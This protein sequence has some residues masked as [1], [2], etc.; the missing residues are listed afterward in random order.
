[1]CRRSGNRTVCLVVF[2]EKILRWFGAKNCLSILPWRPVFPDSSEWAIRGPSRHHVV[3]S[4]TNQIFFYEKVFC[5]FQTVPE[6]IVDEREIQDKRLNKV[7]LDSWLYAWIMQQNYAYYRWCAIVK[8]TDF[9][10]VKFYH[11][12]MVIIGE[13]VSWERCL[14]WT[15]CSAYWLIRCL[16]YCFLCSKQQFQSQWIVWILIWCALCAILP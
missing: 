5:D 9:F 6:N 11:S 8:N 15:W 3:I 12:P 1:M 16:L 10:M 7:V 4:A 2:H 14:V 13:K